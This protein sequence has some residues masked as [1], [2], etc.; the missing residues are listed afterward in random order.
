M[1][2]LQWCIKWCSPNQ[3]G[4]Q[5]YNGK[6]ISI[7]VVVF[8]KCQMMADGNDDALVRLGAEA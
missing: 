8:H 6:Q 3:A 7:S 4:L 1:N 2:L 5:T